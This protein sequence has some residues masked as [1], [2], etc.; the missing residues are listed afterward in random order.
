M[1]GNEINSNNMFD[2][3]NFV[4]S[5]SDQKQSKE[6]LNAR[7]E[8]KEAILKII[9]RKLAKKKLQNLLIE[10]KRH[11]FLAARHNLAD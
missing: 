6:L 2:D 8:Q 7:N 11:S 3:Q 9:L 4:K 5:P 1:R 10:L